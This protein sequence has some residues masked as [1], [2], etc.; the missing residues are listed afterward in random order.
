LTNR[1]GHPLLKRAG[2]KEQE[3]V[4]RRKG[5]PQKVKIALRLR[6]ETAMTTAWIA[7]RLQMGAKTYLS[8]LLYH[9]G[10]QKHC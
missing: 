8:H 1:R 9:Y 2:W 4:A 7:A 10:K 6:K 5:D 3:L